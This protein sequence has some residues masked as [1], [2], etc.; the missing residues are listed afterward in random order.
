MSSSGSFDS[1]ASAK[2]RAL[3]AQIPVVKADTVYTPSINAN[4]SDLRKKTMLNM[5]DKDSDS[6]LKKICANMEKIE[7]SETYKKLLAFNYEQVDSSHESIKS[8]AIA[9]N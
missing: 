7:E 2:A 5:Q 6:L 9:A 3:A 1:Q 4:S 8:S